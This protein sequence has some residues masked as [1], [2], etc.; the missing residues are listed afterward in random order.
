MRAIIVPVIH[1]NVLA[2]F[3][4]CPCR[5]FGQGAFCMLFYAVSP[6]NS[7]QSLVTVIQATPSSPPNNL[8]SGRGSPG[9]CTNDYGMAYILMRRRGV[10]PHT[11]RSFASALFSCKLSYYLATTAGR[12]IT[13][14]SPTDFHL[15]DTARLLF[16]QRRQ[17]SRP[18]FNGSA[19]APILP[20]HIRARLWRFLASRSRLPKL[21]DLL[22]KL[23]WAVT[24]SDYSSVLL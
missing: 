16:A 10:K 14:S 23:M 3:S 21:V 6:M 24:S 18:S 9:I 17:C 22:C 2:G 11:Y 13:P 8:Y 4:G 15:S 19:S 1:G 20:H 5:L 12:P 7:K